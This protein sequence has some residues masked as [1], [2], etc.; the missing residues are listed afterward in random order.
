M[1]SGGSGAVKR[2]ATRKDV[3]GRVPGKGKAVRVGEDE[4]EDNKEEQSE[5]SEGDG[6]EDR[7]T[8]EGSE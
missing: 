7:A 1:L 4:D 5:S 2:T 3:Q 6:G 8:E